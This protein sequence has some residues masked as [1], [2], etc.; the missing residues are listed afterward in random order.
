[1]PATTKNNQALTLPTIDEPELA[2]HFIVRNFFSSVLGLIVLLLLSCV[3][4]SQLISIDQT[5]TASIRDS[6]A[7]GDYTCVTIEAVL[8]KNHSSDNLLVKIKLS[9]KNTF[10]QIIQTATIEKI[11]QTKDERLLYSIVAKLP[12]SLIQDDYRISTAIVITGQVSVFSYLKS[13]FDE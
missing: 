8:N 12:T 11:D 6:N 2:S 9:E 5:T 13:Q 7:C 1:M 4:I 10:S 3:G